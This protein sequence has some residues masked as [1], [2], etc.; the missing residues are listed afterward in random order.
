MQINSCTSHEVG[1]NYLHSISQIEFVHYLQRE[2]N[3]TL[4]K[5]YLQGVKDLGF[6][7]S[8]KIKISVCNHF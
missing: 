2:E 5:H 6:G 7:L 8:G 3:A 1:K 4:P